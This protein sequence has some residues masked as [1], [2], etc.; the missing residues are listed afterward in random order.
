MIYTLTLN[1]AVDKTAI[2]DDFV[3]GG[4]NQLKGCIIDAGGKGIN[5]SKTLRALNKPNMALG[6]I[7]GT[8]GEQIRQELMKLMIMS[9]FVTVSGETRCNLK[10]QSVFGM[11]EFNEPGPKIQPSELSQ[12]LIR[13]ERYAKPNNLFVLSGSLPEGVPNDIYKQII[14]MLHQ[15]GCRVLLDTNGE[16]LRIGMEARPEYLKPNLK[17][18]LYLFDRTN[19]FET[20]EE[21]IAWAKDRAVELLQNGAQFV[22]VSLGELGAVFTDGLETMHAPAM[23][24]PVLS[25]VGA[26]DAMTAAIA[27]GVDSEMHFRDIVRYAM[28]VSAGACMTEGTKP[29]SKDDI[30]KLLR[31]LGPV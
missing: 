2:V 5:V 29:P 7:G 30:V 11:T 4:V 12:L 18:L 15:R 27:Y 26:G 23:D 3:L 21:L 8:Y 19:D 1:P 9:D 25:P 31:Q 16:V 17:E 6:F 20:S 22:A 10:V 24:I 28:A 13:L 14:E